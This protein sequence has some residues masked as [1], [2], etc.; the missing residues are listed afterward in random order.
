[1]VVAVEAGPES[2]LEEEEGC[3]GRAGGAVDRV[4]VAPSISTLL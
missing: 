4:P 3:W 1:M 2:R